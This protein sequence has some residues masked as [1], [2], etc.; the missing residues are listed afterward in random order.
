MGSREIRVRI[1]AL[2]MELTWYGSFPEKSIFIGRRSTNRVSRQMDSSF[3]LSVSSYVRGTTFRE[4]LFPLVSGQPTEFWAKSRLDSDSRGSITYPYSLGYPKSAVPRLFRNPAFWL[5]GQTD[6]QTFSVCKT[7]SFRKGNKDETRRG[8]LTHPR[9][10]LLFPHQSIES[11]NLCE[12][13]YEY[14]IFF[15]AF[16][17]TSDVMRWG[18]DKTD[19]TSYTT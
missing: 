9:L 19:I 18:R 8:R 4:N 1:R 7:L 11:D 2:H 6:T 3:K 10:P 16:S 12:T 17:S 13:I 5:V 14:M 15:L